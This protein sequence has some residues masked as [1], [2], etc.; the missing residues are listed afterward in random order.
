ML[1]LD[2]Q[3]HIARL[4][5]HKRHHHLEIVGLK[6]FFGRK[7]GDGKCF[8]GHVG[9]SVVGQCVQGFVDILEMDMFYEHLV[10]L[11]KVD[12]GLFDQLNLLPPVRI[13]IP[14]H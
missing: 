14:S 11:G 8:H 9:V 7:G 4:F 10:Y 12:D 3:V 13:Y 1:F 6:A 2:K 5:V